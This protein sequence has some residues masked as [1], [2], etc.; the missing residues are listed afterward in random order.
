MTSR[1]VPMSTKLDGNQDRIDLQL[2]SRLPRFLAALTY[3]DLGASATITKPASEATPVVKPT[4]FPVSGVPRHTTPNIRDTPTLGAD[5]KPLHLSGM[6]SKKP[7]DRAHHAGG[8]TRPF[9]YQCLQRSEKLVALLTAEWFQPSE[10][11]HV[12][13]LSGCCLKWYCVSLTWNSE[14]GIL[15]SKQH[16]CHINPHGIVHTV[17]FVTSP[18]ATRDEPSL[19]PCRACNRSD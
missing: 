15:F 7:R 11:G 18:R 16:S 5:Y 3:K 6:I 4:I 19:P 8:P 13:K 10:H 9:Q 2:T 17:R 1:K 12:A 14:A